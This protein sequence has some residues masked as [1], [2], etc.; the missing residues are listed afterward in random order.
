L[1]TK[2][3]LDDRFDLIPEAA[4]NEIYPI[5]IC[6]LYQDLLKLIVANVF[7]RHSAAGLFIV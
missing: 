1:G 5:L 2:I 6:A 4:R 3:I 7:V